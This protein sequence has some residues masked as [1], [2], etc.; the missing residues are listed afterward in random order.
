MVIAAAA[1][2]GSGACQDAEWNW[3]TRWWKQPKRTVRPATRR[4]A[5]GGATT[6]ASTKG[7][8]AE[9]PRDP[10]TSGGTSTETSAAP[11]NTTDVA[12]TAGSPP[13]GTAPPRQG[14]DVF[15]L[16]LLSGNPAAEVGRGDARLQ[17]R[18]VAAR[19]CAEAL[20]ALYVPRGRSGS[21]QESYLLYEQYDLF[22]IARRFA[23]ELDVAPITDP[24]SAPA[25]DP[26]GA[27][28]G[29]YHAMVQRGPR[30]DRTLMTACGE[31][32]R[33]AAQSDRLSRQQ[34][35]AAAILAG[36]LEADFAFDYARAR[37]R[38]T[39]AEQLSA[40]ESVERLTAWWWLADGYRQEGNEAKAKTH[41]ELIA[42]H[43]QSWPKTHVVRRAQEIVTGHKKP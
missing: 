22:D 10:A 28:V 15:H 31:R 2:A 23:P 25:D 27:G 43:G 21:E 12:P 13:A 1:C 42:K 11:A 41:Y 20:E 36:R 14:Q 16:Y 6:R 35:W 32:L 30:V 3:D 26:F 29:M 9:S 33:A 7:S 37:E 5:D 39:E 19:T 18:H 24:A 17:L 38:F 8:I 40:E 4:S 34:R